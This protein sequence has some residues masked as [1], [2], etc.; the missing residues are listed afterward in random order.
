KLAQV[1][2]NAGGGTKIC[3]ATSVVYEVA[4]RGA[5]HQKT[6]TPMLTTA[7]T[8]AMVANLVLGLRRFMIPTTTTARASRSL[9][10]ILTWFSSPRSPISMAP[11]SSKPLTSCSRELWS[12]TLTDLGL[13][14]MTCIRKPARM[15]ARPSM[16]KKRRMDSRML[17]HPRLLPAVVFPPPYPHVGTPERT[18][19]QKGPLPT[20]P[21]E[22]RR[23]VP[24]RVT[25]LYY[26]GAHARQSPSVEKLHRPHPGR[27]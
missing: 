15:P 9:T 5:V 26:F 20:P 16:C 21:F 8:P 2:K 23:T 18:C 22:A 6:A 10:P 11:T 17:M 19:R 4:G 27:R 13:S 12:K 24:F 14:V 3:A 25:S 1:R 7:M